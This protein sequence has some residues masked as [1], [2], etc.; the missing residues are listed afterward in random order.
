MYICFKML[1]SK[2]LYIINSDGKAALSVARHQ[3]LLLRLLYHSFHQKGLWSQRLLVL[4]RTHSAAYV[5][6][7]RGE[8][9]VEQCH[10]CPSHTPLPLYRNHLLL[11]QSH[12]MYRSWHH[13][14]KAHSIVLQE[15]AWVTLPSGTRR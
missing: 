8:R 15:L 12:L 9:S 13:S 3:Q 4:L 2:N 10:P 11:P 1:S 14:P 6:H 7:L 5:L